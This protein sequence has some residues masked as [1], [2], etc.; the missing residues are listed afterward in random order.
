[1][2]YQQIQQL[3]KEKVFTLIFMM[4]EYLLAVILM[5]MQAQLMYVQLIS[6]LACLTFLK[7]WF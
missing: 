6:I 4:A 1:M 5:K 3:Q 7:I 2:C